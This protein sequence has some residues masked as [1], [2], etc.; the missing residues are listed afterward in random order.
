MA[1]NRDKILQKKY[2]GGC[3][4]NLSI[5]KFH[6]NKSQPDG[7]CSQCKECTLIRSK[8]YWVKNKS[9]IKKNY[10]NYKPTDKKTLVC[11]K[12]KKEKLTSKFYKSKQHVNGYAGWCKSC[13]SSSRKKSYNSVSR[14]YY[15]KKL[16]GISVSDYEKMLKSHNNGCWICGSKPKKRRLAVDH[17]HKTGKVRGLL[18]MR[19]NRGLS[20]FSDDPIKLKSAAAYLE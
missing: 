12:C 16:Y 17:S 5:N 19:C 1:Y 2:C 11:L 18:C 20:W 9:K 7:L 10:K 6:K 13:E 14:V 15:L 4:R 8:K 3:R